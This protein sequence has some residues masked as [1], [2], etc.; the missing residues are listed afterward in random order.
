[1]PVSIV[2]GRSSG[3]S[4]FVALLLNTAINYSVTKR[5]DFRVYRDPITCTV[6]GEMLTALKKSMWPPATIKGSLLQYDFSFGYSNVFTRSLLAVKEKAG[7]QIRKIKE[8][9]TTRGELFNTVNFK[10]I[11]IA[12]EDVEM[13]SKFLEESKNSGLPITDSVAPSLLN[14]LGSDVIVFLLDSEKI[15]ADRNDPK[16][17][18][19]LKYDT[20][21]SSL[22]SYIGKYRSR[23][24]KSKRHLF[25][26]F[27]LTKFDAINPGIKK[28]LGIPAEDYIQWVE[29]MS[30]DRTLRWKFF[31]NFMKTFFRSSLSQIYGASLV[32]TE[33]QDAPIFISYALTELNEDGILVPKVVKRG[34][35]N[36]LI[37][38]ETEYES[39]IKYF[40]KI[41]NKISDKKGEE[42]SDAVGIG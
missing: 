11:D 15:A 31:N 35:A 30:N 42:E 4:V 20:I 8:R 34:Q 33:M 7:T 28:S 26:V 32:G 12:G 1:L 2:G 37:Y 13:L 18:E 14:A 23:Y 38:S 27:I 21:M 39:F 17:D 5:N 25:P 41:A 24:E 9:D 22:I 40:G 29:K 19:M 6:T 36:E 16:Y 10:L 3:K